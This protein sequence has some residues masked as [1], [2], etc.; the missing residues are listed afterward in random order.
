MLSFEWDPE[1]E[2]RNFAKH[3]VS[4][5]AAQQVFNDPFASIRLQKIIH[6]EERWQALGYAGGLTL[7]LV[8]HTYRGNDDEAIIRIISARKASPSE[9]RSYG[10]DQ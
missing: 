3:G 4:F 1:K 6:G 8:A 10:R 7:L 2:R 9:S 5:R